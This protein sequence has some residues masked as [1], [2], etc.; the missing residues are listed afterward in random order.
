MWLG[1]PE[2][3]GLPGREHGQ[4]ARATLEGRA[5]TNSMS[6]YLKW[7]LHCTDTYLESF[8]EFLC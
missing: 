1:Y 6:K 3:H 2:W 8:L 4:D 5:T 7:S